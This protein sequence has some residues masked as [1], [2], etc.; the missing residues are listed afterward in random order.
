MKSPLIAF[1]LA[2]SG[3]A[4]AHAAERVISMDLVDAAG[5]PN[6]DYTTDEDRIAAFRKLA[7]AVIE[8]YRQQSHN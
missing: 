6:S 4:G 2:A 5:K 3:M 8:R 7:A 1:L